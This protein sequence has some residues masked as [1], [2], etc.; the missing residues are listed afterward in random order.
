MDNLTVKVIV[1]HSSDCKHKKKGSE[2]RG[3]DCRKSLLIYE[4]GGSGRNR[5]LSV[6]T[7]S[8]EKAE[9]EAQKY[10]DSKDPQKQELK[11]LRAKQENES[12]LITDAI[13][14]YLADMTAR[15]GNNA[16]VGNDR[17]LLADVDLKTKLVKV[18]GHLLRWINNLPVSKRP[19][20]I[21]DITVA[22]LTEWRASWKCGDLTAANR[23]TRTKGFLMFCERQGWIQDN[24]ARKLK[25]LAADRGSRTAIFTDEQYNA[26]LDAVKLYD[27]PTAPLESRNH[28]HQRLTVFIELMRW[29]GMAIVDA[30]QYRP[31]LVDDEGVLRYKRQKTD[32]LAT[33]PLPT[34]VTALLRNVPVAKGCEADQPFRRKNRVIRADKKLWLYRLQSVFAL[35]GITE[36]KNELGR[37]R[38]PHAHM[39]R[40]TFAVWY[41]RHGSRLQV[42]SKMLG[43]AKTAT[44]EQAYLPWVKELEEAYISEARHTL[45]KAV[46]KTSRSKKVVSI[47]AKAQEAGS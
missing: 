9:L 44:T 15:L 12:I 13:A 14:L 46:P 27:P 23:W 4:G 18:S 19:V 8:W 36:V 37:A 25:S 45:A 30:V 3:C 42:V 29:S 24:P 16:T 41:L 20:Y 1:R 22:H 26:I 33:V 7:R 31:E 38:K 39:L 10:R 6:K 43:H 5:R 34:H 11:R 32:T 21:K 47:A 40:D 17:S 28:L 35:A 2:F